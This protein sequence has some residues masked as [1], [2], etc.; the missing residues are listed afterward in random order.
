MHAKVDEGI[1]RS[2]ISSSKAAET[3]HPSKPCSSCSVT[4]SDGREYTS[5]S[6]VPLRWRKKD[7]LRTQDEDF[8]IVEDLAL[9][10]MLARSAM[11]ERPEPNTH[12]I[13]HAPQ[14]EGTSPP[15][16]SRAPKF[17]PLDT[18]LN[19]YRGEKEARPGQRAEKEGTRSSD[20]EGESRRSESA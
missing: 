12:P 4:D 16:D 5:T 3:G 2:I 11:S 15:F 20:E 9:D 8:Y 1:I 18:Y 17:L 10:A 6:Y 7:A 14:T 19:G 13:L